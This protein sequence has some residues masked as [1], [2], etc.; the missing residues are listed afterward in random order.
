MR[1]I[2][3]FALVLCGALGLFGGAALAQPTPPAHAPQIHV[4][5]NSSDELMADLKFLCELAGSQGAKG[6]KTLEPFLVTTFEGTDPKK[7]LVVDV[8]FNASGSDV[9]AHFPLLPLP[10]KPLGQK[11]LANLAGV[12]IHNRRLTAG[13]FQLGGGA[14]VMQGEA[15][16]GFLRILGPP[17]NY[18][19][20]SSDR[21]LLPANLP[22][23]TKG[24]V[25][26]ALL[27]K[28]YDVGL[29]MKNVNHAEADQKARRADFQKARENLLAGLKQKPE[30]TPESFAVQKA[31]LEHNLGELERFIAESDELTLGWITDAPK[32]EARLDFELITIPGSSLE[33]SAKL[34][35]QAPGMFSSVPRSADAM[36]SGRLNFPLDQFRQSGLLSAMPLYR[37]SADARIAA[38]TSKTAEQK[39]PLKLAAKRLFDLIEDQVK[40]GVIDGLIEVSQA[41]GEKANL[42]FAI[43]A[44][45]GQA[46]QGVVELLP[47]I[48]PEFKVTLETEKVGDY[49]IHSIQ[50]PEKEEDFELL[51][52]KGAPVFVA[53]GPKACWVA[54]GT[55]SLVQLKAAI[56]AAGQGNAAMANNFLTLFTRIGPWIEFLEGRRA[57]LD[58]LPSE[59]KLTEAD[60]KDR[61][62]RAALRKIAVDSFKAG[63]GTFETKL[64]AKNGRVT[65]STRFDDGILKFIGAAIADFS[66]K[67]LK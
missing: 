21:N 42:L 20:I 10:P 65:G 63:K 2:R 40:V 28:K 38:S 45:D 24:N 1:I 51:F 57:R 33:T 37:A 46:F 67:T 23:P 60:L 18:A 55:K 13:F 22:D 36:L 59:T 4:T 25:V 62:D 64:D 3:Q 66:N 14:A 56:G 7:P 12:G 11:F 15:Y 44:K 26:A 48:N 54:I 17:I 19:S 49:A 41:N 9:R 35:G 52:G 31:L 50:V 61:K 43:Q 47:Q 27:A 34:L 16:N 58:A 29:L 5:L 32:V 30:D 8:L 39:T 53:T 6:W